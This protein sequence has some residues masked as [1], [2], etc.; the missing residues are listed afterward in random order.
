MKKMVAVRI[1]LLLGVLLLLLSGCTTGGNGVS[2]TSTYSNGL[3]V[4][5]KHYK[6]ILNGSSVL[7]I[8]ITMDQANLN[9][10]R[11]DPGAAE[12]YSAAI[13]IGD[14][15]TVEN[16]GFRTKG[17]TAFADVDEAGNLRYSYKIKFDKFVNKQKYHKL[18]EMV[19]MNLYKDPSY[20]RE[21]LALEVL[22]SLGASVPLASFAK[23][24]INNEYAGLYLCV[25]SVD[26]GFM[27]RV[28][29]NNDGNLYKA[30]VGSTLLDQSSL[31]ALEQKNGD[32]ET[33][34]YLTD[35]I[36]KL[37]AMPAG[38]KGDIESILN[39]DSVLMYAAANT[40]MGA[41]DSYSGKDA[42]NYYLYENSGIFSLIP[43]DYHLA[44]GASGKDN[45]SSATVSLDDPVFRTSLD[46]RPLF[47]KLLAVEEYKTKYNE[48]VER[49]KTILAGLHE[50]VE[51]LDAQIG[52]LVEQDATSF[53]GYE[54]YL[55]NIGRE[56][57]VDTSGIVSLTEYV[58]L[59]L[60]AVNR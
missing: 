31:S 3:D 10:L 44:F 37:N 49:L 18:D 42:N 34:S 47:Q 38:G 12:Y 58:S 40:M 41:Y 9:A 24:T 35:L 1:G 2:P 22:R 48:Y 23:L 46:Q 54:N 19:L 57:H 8:K 33:K 56:G 45:G 26:D 14:D 43:W 17:N 50:K 32:D 20:M 29:G 39:V 52:S 4:G 30:E 11:D 15:T 6:D 28:F 7:D 13:K 16:V 27:N 51:A 36:S 53:Y 60:A 59:R 25:E 21:Y 55:A 5:S